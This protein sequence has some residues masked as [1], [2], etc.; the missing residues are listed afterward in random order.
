MQIKNIAI[1]GGGSS[2]WMTAAALAK[3]FPNFNITLIESK[4][5]PIIGVG[6]S[7]LAQFNEYLDLLDIRDED[8]MPHCSATY[9]TSIRFA[10]FIG[11]GKSY[12]DILKTPQFPIPISTVM[13]FFLVAKL[14]PSLLDVTDF[15]KFFD[16]TH[17]MIESNKLT[18]DTS[19]MKWNFK[20]DTAYHLD[21]YKFGQCLKD[22]I[23][24][25]KGVTHIEDDITNVTVDESGITGLV[26]KENGTITAD[27]YVDCSGF[28]SML[29]GEALGVEFTSFSETLVN[30]R[31]VVANIPYEDK[32]TELNSWTDCTAIE[33]GWLWNIPIWDRV[34][35]GYVY[36]S[37]FVDDETALKQYKYH[38]RKRYGA[39][40]N[41][42]EPKYI[43][44]TPGVR[45]KPW[46]KNVVGVGLSTGFLEPLRS[47]GLLVT[48]QAITKLVTALSRNN[49][50]IRNV[51][52]EAFSVNV[53]QDVTTYRDFVSTHYALAKRTD[54]PYWKHVTEEIEYYNTE[55]AL[56]QGFAKI[57]NSSTADLNQTPSIRIYTGAGY[58][59]ITDVQLDQYARAGVV[60]G[61][62]IKELRRAWLA[63]Y[64][65]LKNYIDALPSTYQFIKNK[66][67]KDK[68]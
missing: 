55:T 46:Y 52:R 29:L 48:H 14:D 17:Y 40:A 64:E 68:E 62:G 9:K 7:T 63:H 51:D 54:T 21:A 31:A 39:R 5:V 42:I 57:T 60:S 67:Y 22:L 25:P 53:K 44:F 43:K 27:L 34:G 20:Y 12:H 59:P 16:D 65:S 33:N 30:D 26:T 24:I 11:P 56:Y 19:V 47:T 1:V 36:S 50:Y 28:K 35:T 6:E 4:N 38:L 66:I 13:D 45:N 8:W 61:E 10:D 2:G 3:C 49:G 23:A 32:E 41:D 15:A 58:N 18:D 37:K